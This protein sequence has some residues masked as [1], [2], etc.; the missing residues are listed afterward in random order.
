LTGK[1]KESGWLKEDADEGNRNGKKKVRT[2]VPTVHG[3]DPPDNTATETRLNEAP[4]N[5]GEQ[6]DGCE[7]SGS[8]REASPVDKDEG[9]WS[10]R[11]RVDSRV[12]AR[13]WVRV[14]IRMALRVRRGGRSHAWT[15]GGTESKEDWKMGKTRNTS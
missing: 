11:V 1:G 7:V 2:E 6:G 8:L 13:V 10:V 5:K 9:R 4:A 15:N 14:A 3:E 12:R